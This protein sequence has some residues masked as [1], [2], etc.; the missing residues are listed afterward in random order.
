M[1]TKGDGVL[2]TRQ[3]ANISTTIPNKGPCSEK[4]WKGIIRSHTPLVPFFRC[5]AKQKH[6]KHQCKKGN[7]KSYEL[8]YA[9][10]SDSGPHWQ[11]LAAVGE[12]FLRQTHKMSGAMMTPN[13]YGHGKK[14][15]I[16]THWLPLTAIGGTPPMVNIFNWLP[17]VSIGT[18]G[19]WLKAPNI[20]LLI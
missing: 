5:R 7:S 17:L 15:I 2:R 14:K 18:I 8:N 20:W 1:T 11:P 9:P 16:C 6:W 19:S 4:Q 10:G 13:R 3:P 12:G